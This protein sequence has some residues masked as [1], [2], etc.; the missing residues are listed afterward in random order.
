MVNDKSLYF[1]YVLDALLKWHGENKNNDI[2]M[3]KAL[4]LLFFIT[5]VKATKEEAVLLDK[6]FNNYYA[7]PLGP[8]ESDIYSLIKKREGNLNF[9]T[10]DNR[11]LTRNSTIA[12][13]SPLNSV[14]TKEIDDS[15]DLLKENY[16]HLIKLTPFQLVDL[17]HLWHSWK[18][19]YA[20]ATNNSAP[21]D[22]EEIK[23]DDKIFFF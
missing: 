3:L 9:F 6:I 15:V 7:M 16:S 10:L 21:M 5:T 1:E 20:N 11:T 17:T 12:N 14:F 18:K 13:Y 2:S 4:K 19:P 23:T 22:N 8:V